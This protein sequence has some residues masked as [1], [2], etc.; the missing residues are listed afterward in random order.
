M[1]KVLL[2]EPDALVVPDLYNATTMDGVTEYVL[3]Q[4]RMAVVA[5]RARDAVE[6][7]L[8]IL[9]LKTAP[10][11]FAR[12]VTAVL[13]QR[14]VRKLCETCRQ[15]YEPPKQLLEKLGI[16]AGAVEVLY[17]EY[18]PPPPG[19]KRQKGEPE[20]CPDCRGIG[21]RGRTGVFELVKVSDEM[22]AALLRQPQVDVLRQLSRKAGNRTLQEEGVLLVAQ[23]VT[24]LNELQR[25][26]KQ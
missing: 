16:P 3:G 22:R 21:Y 10:E 14:L 9:A 15:A 4:Q 13:G 24:S 12:S 11:R 23:G 18:Q 25:V 17:R 26:L 19:S 1:R 7:L 5:I 20:I 6:A 2:R 8:R